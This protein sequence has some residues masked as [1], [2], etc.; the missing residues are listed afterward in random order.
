MAEPGDN[1]SGDHL[2]FRSKW[3]PFGC[4]DDSLSKCLMAHLKTKSKVWM[5]GCVVNVT[6]FP[7]YSNTELLKAKLVV[8][9]KVK[10]LANKPLA[11][12][13]ATVKGPQILSF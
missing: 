6:I 7:Q 8:K 9:S 4:I 13:I 5:I 2:P 3:A 1:Q 11:L 12:I 10:L